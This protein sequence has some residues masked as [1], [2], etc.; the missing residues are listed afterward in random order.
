MA[1]DRTL[2]QI[3]ERS[4]LDLLDLA[5]IVVRRRPVTLGLAALS[6]VA[7]WAALDAWL[8]GQPGVSP[9]WWIPLVAM[10]GPW[11]TAPMTVVLG[12]LMFG[13]RP[14][15]SR[16][17]RVLLRALPPM[18]LYQGILR[19]LLL[20]TVIFSPVIPSKLAFLDEVILL[21]KGKWRAALGRSSRLCGDRWGE[22]TFQWMVLAALGALFVAAFRWS[23]EV[24][25]DLMVHNGIG[26]STWLSENPNTP[27]Q[28]FTE[29]FDWRGQ[30]GLWIVVSFAGLVRF[31]TYIDRR[32]RLEGWEVELRLRLVGA[33]MEDP[34]R[35]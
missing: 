16:V 20:L 1:L 10:E 24:L 6:G 34:E 12:G 18:L 17:V 27:A 32:I 22:L 29:M 30:V 3:R 19:G 23:A 8:M 21:E 26:E 2:V 9:L 11:A 31:L 14:P 5:L 4:F 15:V 13:E 28:W 25:V 33:A 7:P 35:W